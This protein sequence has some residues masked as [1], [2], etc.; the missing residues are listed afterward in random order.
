MT[1]LGATG[2]SSVTLEPTDPSSVLLE[3]VDVVEEK[4]VVRGE[5][6]ELDEEGKVKEDGIVKTYKDTKEYLYD[7]SLATKNIPKNLKHY[8]Q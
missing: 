3:S 4:E 7:M 1:A 5:I 8:T 2:P 6:V